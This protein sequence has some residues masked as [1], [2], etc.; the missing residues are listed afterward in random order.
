[1]Y[2]GIL[3]VALSF[4]LSGCGQ[5]NRLDL[6]SAGASA[7]KAIVFMAIAP[8]CP[9]PVVGLTAR[10]GEDRKAI[11]ARP[12]LFLRK[13]SSELVRFGGLG[14]VSVARFDLPPGTYQL[15]R[16]S[17]AV[18]NGHRV[19]SRGY[20]RNGIA[21]FTVAPRETVNIGTFHEAAV[22]RT[23]SGIFGSYQQNTGRAT[24]HIAPMSEAELSALRE[25]FP[26]EAARAVYRPMSMDVEHQREQDVGRCILDGLA[27]RDKTTK[28]EADEI[29]AL[30][31][32]CKEKAARL[33]AAPAQ[34][35]KGNRTTARA[36]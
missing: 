18:N 11:D 4:A 22:T 28:M 14:D 26:E 5:D 13:T 9:L 21:S 27:K 16:V 24:F 17:C 8:T 7:D 20:S 34:A 1:M 10:I 31:A 12:G 33:K 25:K 3:F 32:T 23:V 29:K 30:S 36:G 35:P 15:E 6:A 19:L 2:K